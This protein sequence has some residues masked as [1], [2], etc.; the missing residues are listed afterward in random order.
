MGEI[1]KRLSVVFAVAIAFSACTRVQSEVAHFNNLPAQT[2][3]SS[4]VVVP[5]DSQV[6]SAQFS[7]YAASIS[8]RLESLGFVTV[9]K[10]DDADYVVVFDFGV[11]GSRQIS[12]SMPVFGQ[13]GGGTTYHSGTASAFGTGGSAW[14]TYSGTS[15]TP[16]TY[17]VTGYVPYSRAEHDRY[18]W[19]KMYDVKR[20]TKEN[21]VA[22]YEATVTSSGAASNFAIVAECIFDAAFHNFFKNGAERVV[23]NGDKCM[24]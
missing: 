3:G 10:L 8:R 22:A 15:Y 13:T 4:F 23:I 6:G 7:Q 5:T 11:K 12:G 18:F 2:V 1:V 16:P 20:S 9:G 14:G 19:L 21:L 24:R 17:G